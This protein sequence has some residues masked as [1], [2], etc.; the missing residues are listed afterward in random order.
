MNNKKIK[1]NLWSLKETRFRPADI[2]AGE[3]LFALGNGY[4]GMRGTF[5][6]GLSGYS[7]EGTY[8]NGFYEARPIA[9]GEKM[10]GFP[11]TGQTMLNIANGK[12]IALRIGEERFSLSEGEIRDY[13]RELN[14]KTGIL[15]RRIHW[16]SPA[17]KEIRISTERSVLFSR[18]HIACLVY[19]VTPVNFTGPVT[20]ISGIED[21]PGNNGGKDSDKHDP[22]QAESFDRDVLFR[23][24]EASGNN[25]AYLLQQT[26][27]S[28]L[29]LACGIHHRIISDVPC[30]SIIFEHDDNIGEEFTYKAEPGRE[31]IFHKYVSYATSLD[32]GEESVLDLM[33]RELDS[34]VT[35]GMDLLFREQADF[36]GG[37]WEQADMTIDGDDDIQRGLRFNMFHLLQS[38]GQSGQSNIAAKGLTGQGYEGHYFWDTETYIL[39]FFLYTQP[40]ISRS[41]LEYRYRTLDGARNRARE[42]SHGRGALYP[43][44]TINGSE[45]SANFPTGTAQYHINADI[46][47]AI[48]RYMDATEDW[49]FMTRFG[50]EMLFETSRFWVDAG[51]FNRDG[52]FCITSVTGPDEYTILVNN[53]AYT[54]FMAREHLRF[55][56]ETA[57][58]LR[59]NNPAG[60]AAVCRAVGLKD[61][62]PLQWKKA[63]DLMLIPRDEKSGV[64]PQ[65]DSFFGKPLWDFDGTPGENYP[66]LLHY[67]PL[68]LNRYQVCKQADL[69]LAEFLLNDQFDR[70]QKKRDYDYYKG[71]TTHDSSLSACIFGIMAAELGYDEE[72]YRYFM[73][74]ATTDLHDKKG[75]TRDGIHTASM[76]GSWMGMVF[77]FAGMRVSGGCLSFNPILPEKW[78]SY[79]FRITYRGRLLNVSV[80]RERADIHLL[81]GNPLDVVLSGNT[82]HLGDDWGE[83]A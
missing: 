8:I 41:L 12:G 19:R 11:E 49:E 28:R 35:A 16:R 61:E 33:H 23:L 71:I 44:R 43:W 56:Y 20:L 22:R 32:T 9:Y 13:H 14:M 10:H 66:L 73:E 55:A 26:R 21:N 70:D 46:A 45:C 47:F 29:R 83:T 17:G 30:H 69:L 48:K 53:N 63:A 64:I 77:G 81:R 1:K 24:D 37:F 51:H 76:A 36:L 78:K 38:T 31:I 5:E 6:E 34:A 4:L 74:T 2:P 27:S 57:L 59:G 62:E 68:I 60:Y 82:I 75:N 54:N 42:M 79:S 72:S 40:K 58:I 7:T 18:V 67:H 39:P 80:S 65:D 15:S 25:R 50:A 3:S 52:R